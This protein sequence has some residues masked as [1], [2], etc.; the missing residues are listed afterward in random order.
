MGE[1][2]CG[3]DSVCVRE[4]VGECVGGRECVWESVGECV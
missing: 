4:S 1:R 3:R 2:E